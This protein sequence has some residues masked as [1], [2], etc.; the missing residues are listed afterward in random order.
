MKISRM[1]AEFFLSD[2]QTERPDEADNRSSRFC[3][4]TKKEKKKEILP[5]CQ[6]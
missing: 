1:E 4:V 5:A 2:G 6:Y 3:N